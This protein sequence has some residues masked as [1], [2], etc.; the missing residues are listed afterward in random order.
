MDSRLK[1]YWTDRIGLGVLLLIFFSV[2]T[3]FATDKYAAWI[4]ILLTTTVIS[5]T[6]FFVGWTYQL[7]SFTFSTHTSKKYIW[8]LFLAVST[9]IFS[10][11]MI[12][13]G[14]LATFFVL[15]VAYFMLH[16]LFN[17]FTLFKNTTGREANPW[18]IA[19]T[20]SLLTGSIFLS[21]AHPSSLITQQFEYLIRNDFLAQII[22]QSSVL[23]ALSFKL[24]IVCLVLAF[25]I[26]VVA[27][28]RD[29]QRWHW[30]MLAVIIGI[31]LLS[32]IFYPLNYI[33]VITSILL[34][35]FLI[36]FL[37]YFRRFAQQDNKQ[38]KKYLL[39][40]AAVIIPFVPILFPGQ[41]QEW[42][43]GMIFNAHVTLTLTAVHVTTSLMSEG[44]FQT[45]IMRLK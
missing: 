10:V 30:V 35:H 19:S 26:E 6:H 4:I 29:H 16:G 5:F 15:V 39:L 42:I 13:F 18:L 38:L 41:M 45:Q 3:F 11:S 22:L 23:S 1:T 12:M 32:F 25:L 36:W 43:F 40:H 2:A 31:G 14:Q 24:G 27:L 9:I 8:F 33:F 44:W 37:Q 21:L 28:A 7:K 34:Y 17:E 20:T